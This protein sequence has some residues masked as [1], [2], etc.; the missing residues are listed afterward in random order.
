MQIVFCRKRM[1][2]VDFSPK[3]DM[4][5]LEVKWNLERSNGTMK[6]RILSSALALALLMGC[7][8]EKKPIDQDAALKVSQSEPVASGPSASTEPTEK[9]SEKPKPSVGTSKPS[10]SKS[11][12]QTE[13]SEPVA[14][15]PPKPSEPAATEP[16]P[17]K[18]EPTEPVP[19]EPAPTEPK[20]TAHTHSYSTTVVAPTCTAEG[21]TKHTCSCGEV[22]NDGYAAALGHSYTDTIVEATTSSEGYTEHTCSRCGDT[23]RD[24][25]TP[26]IETSWVTEAEVASLC[27]ELNAY[28][29]SIGFT[30]DA[31]F[32][33]SWAGPEY[34]RWGNSKEWIISSFKEG[35]DVSWTLGWKYFNFTYEPDPDSPGNFIIYGMWG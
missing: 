20:P 29:E 1:E 9:V 10:E 7:A 19:T 22:Y 15:Q 35:I 18:P 25:Y 13:P 28:A 14:S 12:Q 32:A 5:I 17:T 31:E 21:Y 34:T 30:I 6:K 26:I 27:A 24:N 3:H 4:I 33:Q 11:A 16:T 8:E 2:G 23:F